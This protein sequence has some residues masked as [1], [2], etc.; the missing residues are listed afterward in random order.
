MWITC[1]L[2]KFMMWTP[3]EW[4]RPFT[5]FVSANICHTF[6][7]TFQME[8][9]SFPFLELWMMHKK[10]YLSLKSCPLHCFCTNIE[11]FLQILWPLCDRKII[12]NMLKIHQQWCAIMKMLTQSSWDIMQLYSDITWCSH[13]GIT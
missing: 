9:K 1:C 5:S 7:H 11:W 12:W 4:D 10:I 8:H 13:W 6:D 3:Q 2:V